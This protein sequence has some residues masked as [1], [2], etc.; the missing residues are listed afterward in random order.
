M[1]DFEGDESVW[2][3]VRQG[4]VEKAFDDAEAVGATV[5]GENGVAFDFGAEALDFGAGYVGK[6]GNDEIEGAGDFFEE[7][8]A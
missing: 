3:E 8:A 4:I 5:E 1:A 6:V 7:I 2:I